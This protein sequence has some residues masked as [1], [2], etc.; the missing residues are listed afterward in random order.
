MAGANGQTD[1]L[2][3]MVN[4]VERVRQRLL[5]ATGALAK[6][7]VA[8]AVVGGNAVA[9]WVA[10]VD[11]AAVRNTQ[12]VDIL[13][14]REDFARA[15]AALE[16]AGMVHRAAAGIDLF[17]DH[18]AAKARDAVRIVYAREFVRAGEPQPNPDVDA[19]TDLGQ[20][21]VLDPEALVSINLTAFRD[22]DR[23]HV[24]D[25]IGIG[26]VDGSWPARL[27]EPLGGRLQSL[28]DTP[29]G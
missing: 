13:I 9:A 19:S 17:L 4:A 18:P 16:A 27:P 28:L 1:V 23:T 3:R 8:H 7:G 24:R 11:E 20:F 12:D 10:T 14:R 29:E 5:L 25:L 15:K 6:A 26:L 22:K 2:Q 21:R